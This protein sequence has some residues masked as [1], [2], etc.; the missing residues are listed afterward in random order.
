MVP[1]ELEAPGEPMVEVCVICHRFTRYWW[2]E[3]CA[4][5]CPS[6]AEAAT[7]EEMMRRARALKLGPLPK[8]K[9]DA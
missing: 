2:G 1:V 3:G 8:E 7:H 5:L 9:P 4:P 6:C